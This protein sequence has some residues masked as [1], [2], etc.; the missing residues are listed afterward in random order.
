M[1]FALLPTNEIN[2]RPLGPETLELFW[3][4]VRMD[5][6]APRVGVAPEPVQLTLYPA[7]PPVTVIPSMGVP[8]ALDTVGPTYCSDCYGDVTYEPRQ[9]RQY[10]GRNDPNADTY[11]Y[12]VNTTWHCPS[13]R[14]CDACQEH[15]HSFCSECDWCSE[16]CECAF[17]SACENMVRE[18]EDCCHRCDSCCDCVECANCD[19]RARPNSHENNRCGACERCERCGC[20]CEDEDEDEDG[21]HEN[22]APDGTDK[23]LIGIEIEFKGSRTDV[24]RAFANSQLH[25]WKVVQDGSVYDGAELVSPPMDW[26]LT[27]TQEDLA[28]AVDLLKRAGASTSQS[29]GIHVHV[30][31]RDLDARQASKV[32]VWS[33]EWEDQ[34]YRIASSG[35]RTVR[36][37]GRNN[38][39]APMPQDMAIML[40]NVQSRRDFNLAW[41]GSSYAGSSH[42]DNS[43][44]RGVNL[45]SWSYRG[46][47][48]FRVF[49]SSLNHARISAY[50]SLCV[51]VV[52]SARDGKTPKP[53]VR[54]ALGMMQDGKVTGTDAFAALVNGLWQYLSRGDIEKLQ[55]VWDTSYAQ[56][57]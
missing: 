54:Y 31:A 55:W 52:Q 29:A 53:A 27:Q 44:Y 57:A 25:G 47:V 21:F 32:A 6:D 24:A 19:Y 10:V 46:T 42:Y 5:M 9:R 30:D 11:G 35:W 26:D 33:H 23:H 56:A 28:I 18:T 39:C 43:R 41:Y 37:S 34:L 36:P 49:N 50:V 20:D 7:Y 38:Y 22:D 14:Y 12:V 17:C 8:I 15:D 45:H 1:S 16:C 51:A 4:V 40:D 13:T 48:E 2:G 3:Q